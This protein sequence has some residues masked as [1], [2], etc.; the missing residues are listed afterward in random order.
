MHKWA[1]ALWV[2]ALWTELDSNSDLEQVLLCSSLI[3]YLT[4]EVLPALGHRRREKILDLLEEEGM[5]KTKLAESLG[6]RR[7]AI[8]RLA[9]EGRAWRR[10][11]LG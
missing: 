10:E 11:N 6:T 7:T 1:D 3:T 8:T 2:K 5:D 9:E 4:Q